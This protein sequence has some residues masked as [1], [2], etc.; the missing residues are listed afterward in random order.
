MIRR[1]LISRARGARRFATEKKEAPTPPVSSKFK[2]KGK[3]VRGGSAGGGAQAGGEDARDLEMMM[4]W[5]EPRVA[6]EA[7]V[8][9]PERAA[10][11]EA[12]RLTFR[13]ETTRRSNRQIRARQ[14]QI[15]VKQ[16]A[17]A[18]LPEA[19]RAHAETIDPTAYPFSKPPTLTPPIP[20]FE[21]FSSG[22]TSR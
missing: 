4:E 17:L 21:P 13:Q 2:G 20:G 6:A 14:R 5:I 3:Q 8:L 11:V 12:I 15:E 19:L 9:S 22:K 7:P 16:R 18:A 1:L 10:E